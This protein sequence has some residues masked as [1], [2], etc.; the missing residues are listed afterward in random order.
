MGVRTQA[1]AGRALYD[2]AVMDRPAATVAQI[3]GGGAALL[4]RTQ[5]CHSVALAGLLPCIGGVSALLPLVAQLD[6]PARQAPS[7]RP[8]LDASKSS[9][10]YTGRR[11]ILAA[12]ASLVNTSAAPC[13]SR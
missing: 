3:G 7:Q 9:A 2:L 11:K 12:A 8:A 13:P 1:A 4:E 6:L 5:I 10:E